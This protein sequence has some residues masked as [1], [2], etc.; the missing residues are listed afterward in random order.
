MKGFESVPANDFI[1]QLL[2]LL[3][4]KLDQCAAAG[5]NQV[6]VMGVFVVVL[7]QHAAVMEFEL[8]S[9]TTFFQELQSAIHRGEPDRRVLGFDDRVQIF[10][11]NVTF[12]IQKHIK[13][14]IALRCA[15]EPRTLEMFLEDLLF[16]TFHNGPNG[17]VQIIHA[18]ISAAKP[19]VPAQKQMG[20][21]EGEIGE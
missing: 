4:V 18:R 8:A 13:N 16:F 17:I 14:Q 21:L 1:L 5:A 7:I 19:H 6:V 3:V 20:E 11:G 10:A 15:F 12:G 9:Q 2:D